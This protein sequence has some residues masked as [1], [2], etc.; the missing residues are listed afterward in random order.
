MSGSP[1]YSFILVGICFTY[2][3]VDVLLLEEDS[4]LMPMQRWLLVSYIS[5]AVF[6]ST[7]KLGKRYS[8]AESNFLFSLRQKDKVA[9]M[10]VIFTWCLLLPFFTVWTILGTSWLQE[11][12]R[13]SAHCANEGAH[14]HLIFFWQLLSYLWI[15]IHLIY[16]G[17]ATVIEYRL[18][19]Y[20]G[21]LRL[22]ENEDSVERWGRLAP[23]SDS[24]DQSLLRHN[25]CGLQPSKILALPC[26]EFKEDQGEKDTESGC[27]LGCP[28]CLSDFSEGES[29][30]ALPGCGHSFHKACIDLWLLRRADCP[31]C[32]ADVS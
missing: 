26:D 1:N 32:K 23:A 6:M 25:D 3:L 14:P 9:Q 20:E 15:L 29:I 31:M 4:C 19:Q 10:I 30:R 21:N 13:T 16:F 22:I 8:H 2:S 18:R 28:I 7:Q 11:T 17:I 12:L 5:I 27:Q 24:I